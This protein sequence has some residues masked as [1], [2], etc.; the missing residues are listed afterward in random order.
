MYTKNTSFASKNLVESFAHAH[1]VLERIKKN[2]N[3][4][5]YL[6]SSRFFSL[7]QKLNVCEFMCICIHFLLSYASKW[8]EAESEIVHRRR[9][10][11][12]LAF[13]YFKWVLYFDMR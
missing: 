8:M 1:V 7:D 12:E 4:F 11:I 6:S 2:K 5:E 9:C 3:W 10:W 13:N